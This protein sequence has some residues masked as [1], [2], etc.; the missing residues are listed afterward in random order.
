MKKHKI[1]LEE[2]M[3]EIRSLSEYYPLT[4]EDGE[5]FEIPA[6]DLKPFTEELMN[7]IK[8]FLSQEEETTDE[9]SEE[10]D[11]DFDMFMVDVD[12]DLS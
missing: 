12:D 4:V 2:L 9:D 1:F 11:D 8:K 6:S 10:D 7:T 3:D 5:L